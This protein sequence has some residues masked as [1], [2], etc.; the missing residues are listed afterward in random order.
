LIDE[1]GLRISCVIRRREL[2][3]RGETVRPAQLPLDLEDHV[4]LPGAIPGRESSSF[5]AVSSL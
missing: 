2:A 1:R 5:F 4:G 3:D